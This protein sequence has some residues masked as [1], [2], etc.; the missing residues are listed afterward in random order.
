MIFDASSNLNKKKGKSK[1]VPP[2]TQQ[3]ILQK[4]VFL[5]DI[6]QELLFFFLCKMIIFLIKKQ[7]VIFQIMEVIL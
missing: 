7:D 2:K 4:Y 1:L 6:T 5:L 3:R